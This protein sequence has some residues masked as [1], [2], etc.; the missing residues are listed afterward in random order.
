MDSSSLVGN[1]HNK[2]SNFPVV[3]SNSGHEWGVF[4][5]FPLYGQLWETIVAVGAFNVM[6]FDVGVGCRGK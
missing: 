5:N 3:S 2:W 6:D 1:V 4:V